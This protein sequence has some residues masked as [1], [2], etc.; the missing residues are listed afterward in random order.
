MTDTRSCRIKQH[1]VVRWWFHSFL[2]RVLTHSMKECSASVRAVHDGKRL[3]LTACVCCWWDWVSVKAMMECKVISCCGAAAHA[4]SPSHVSDILYQMCVGGLLRGA[5]P[6]ETRRL[7]DFN[8]TF[9]KQHT[10]SFLWMLHIFFD[11][12]YIFFWWFLIWS[13][14]MSV[15]N[16]KYVSGISP[17]HQ[18]MWPL[19]YLA[20]ELTE[21]HTSLISLWIY[22]LAQR[23]AAVY[24]SLFQKR[25]KGFLSLP[26]SKEAS[27]SA[28]Q[29]T[30]DACHARS[31]ASGSRPKQTAVGRIL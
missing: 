12:L 19:I 14:F 3:T 20:V 15:C 2:I 30:K 4:W 25:K 24:L 11:I 18:S 31:C 28:A 27:G 23:L 8:T 29:R 7:T 21:N 13:E 1:L 26:Q 6:A 22:L 17:W 10:T 9:P 5:S 16:V